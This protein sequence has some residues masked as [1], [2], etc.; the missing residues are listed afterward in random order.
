MTGHFDD[1]AGMRIN[2]QQAGRSPVH[3]RPLWGRATFSLCYKRRV[4]VRPLLILRV[5][6]RNW[7][8][9]VIPQPAY[10][11]AA[12]GAWDTLHGRIP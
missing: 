10:Q 8:Q 3:S 2:G 11:S 4:H 1:L 9:A 12:R 5:R 7:S 6:G